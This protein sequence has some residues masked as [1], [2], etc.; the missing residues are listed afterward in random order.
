MRQ[1]SAA[2]PWRMVSGARSIK[3]VFS[4]AS[5]AQPLQGGCESLLGSQAHHRR[6]ANQL[7]SAVAFLH[8]TVDQAWLYLPLARVAPSTT[9][10]EPLAKVGR[11]RIKVEIQSV[12]GKEREAERRPISVAEYG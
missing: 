12:T 10:R 6:D 8:L 9:Q 11:E 5:E 3:A 2:I 4:R 7:A 1:A